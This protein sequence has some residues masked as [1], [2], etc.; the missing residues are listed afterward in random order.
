MGK[1][2]KIVRVLIAKVGLDGHD[3][4]AKALTLGLRDQGMEVIYTGLRETPESIVQIAIQEAVDVI[5][6]SSLSAGH[7]RHFPRVAELLVENEM[8]NVLLIGGGIIPDEDIVELK[9]K[10]VKEIFGPGTDIETVANFIR[11]NIEH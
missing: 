11:E 8:D 1:K 5:G 7:M 10:G 3:R 9:K 2:G 4:G 6:L